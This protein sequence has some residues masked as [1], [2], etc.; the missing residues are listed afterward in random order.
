MAD[1]KSPNL[2]IHG[3]SCNRQAQGERENEDIEGKKD[4]RKPVKPTTIIRQAVK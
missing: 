1:H 4:D 2:R 3:I